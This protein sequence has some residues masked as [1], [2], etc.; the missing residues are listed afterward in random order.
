MNSEPKPTRLRRN[1]AAAHG[2]EDAPKTQVRLTPADIL[3][4]IAPPITLPGTSLF[5]IERRLLR[6][7]ER[8]ERAMNARIRRDLVPQL[9]R[10]KIPSL[11]RLEGLA[12]QVAMLPTRR[13]CLK[14]GEFQIYL[15][16]VH[17]LRNAIAMAI[18]RIQQLEHRDEQLKHLARIGQIFIDADD[19]VLSTF[20]V[21][22]R[23]RAG[24][25]L[26]AA[27][28]AALRRAS[29]Q[30]LSAWGKAGVAAR[31]QKALAS[32]AVSSTPS[33]A[34]SVS[35]ESGTAPSLESV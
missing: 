33:P 8:L 24:R 2:R 12:K 29:S 13:K 5:A 3:K 17:R 32:A 15:D 27:A 1:S 23:N 18:R 22:R 7:R 28:M 35:S 34:E 14:R 10:L 4:Q 20:I 26:H 16:T 11:V 21:S 25:N 6:R 31:R 30:Q 9:R 19:A